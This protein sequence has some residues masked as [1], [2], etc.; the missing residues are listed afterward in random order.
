[1]VCIFVKA[2]TKS[3]H[4]S[5]PLVKAEASALKEAIT[6]IG[7]LELSR[8]VIELRLFASSKRHKEQLQKS[9]R[10]SSYYK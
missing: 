10:V 2:I 9:I 6:R 4:G 1:M 5:P 7:E 8:V 3:F